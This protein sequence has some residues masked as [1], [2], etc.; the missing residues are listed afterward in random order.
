MVPVDDDFSLDVPIENAGD[1]IVLETD[2]TY[3]PAERSRR[4]QDRRHL[5]L[6]I[7]TCELRAF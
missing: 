4:T 7:L 2:Q 5:G 3:V 1:T 6:R